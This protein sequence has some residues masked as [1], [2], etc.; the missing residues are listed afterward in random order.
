MLRFRF[1]D[2]EKGSFLRALL[3]LLPL[4]IACLW[5]IPTSAS[6]SSSD[7]LEEKFDNL[8]RETVCLYSKDPLCSVGSKAAKGI[9]EAGEALDRLEK[10]AKRLLDEAEVSVKDNLLEFKNESVVAQHYNVADKID[11]MRLEVDD[12]LN[13]LEEREKASSFPL[14]FLKKSKKDY[15]IDINEILG[16]ME[17]ILFDGPII[18]FTDSIDSA[19]RNIKKLNEKKATLNE[20][21]AFAPEKGGFF[22]KSKTE[23]QEEL[24]KIKREIYENR[25]LVDELEYELKRKLS[26][27]GVNFSR[28]QIRIL[29]T[30]VDKQNL[31]ESFALYDVTR[32]ITISLQNIIDEGEFD[33]TS[34]LKYYGILIILAEFN[35]FIQ[36]QHIKDID[37]KYLPNLDIIELD[38]Q[39]TI[40]FA[41]SSIDEM[42]DVKNINLLKNNVLANEVSLEIISSY[43]TLLIK[44]KK[45]L[46]EA[47]LITKEK[48]TVAYS[49][50]DTALNA[51]NLIELLRQSSVN[52]ETIF[53]LQIPEITEFKTAAMQDIYFDISQKLLELE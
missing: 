9:K 19:N 14:L 49:S 48:A 51:S 25:K 29:T 28:E 35:S 36:L 7:T 20:S 17:P 26:G 53:N 45:M 24:L 46:Q 42:S 8:A 31:S 6:E 50:Y 44:Q 15:Q 23:L 27:L 32:K 2:F 1:H 37:E 39:E 22:K 40:D 21:I 38:I 30:R 11:Y 47:N 5:H 4:V 16:D 43:K 41:L 3:F 10:N 12:F 13:L 18:N 52:F 34:Y 33:S